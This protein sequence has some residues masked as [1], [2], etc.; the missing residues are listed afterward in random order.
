CHTGAT[1]CFSESIYQ[2]NEAG[3]AMQA[4]VTFLAELETLIKKRKSESYTNKRKKSKRQTT[5]RKHKG[6]ISCSYR[7]LFTCLSY[8]L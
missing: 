5:R 2:N 8:F 4:N 1:S 3:Q 7:E 6:N